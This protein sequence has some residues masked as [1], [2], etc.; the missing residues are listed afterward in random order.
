MT[1]DPL[2]ST[3]AAPG[4]WWRY[5]RAFIAPLL[6]WFIVLGAMWPLLSDWVNGQAVFNRDAIQEWLVE[7]RNPTHTLSDLVEGYIKRSREYQDLHNRLLA[8]GQQPGAPSAGF[9]GEVEE[10]LSPAQ[11]EIRDLRYRHGWLRL[12]VLP[13]KRFEIAEFLKSLGEPPTKMYPGQLP[14]F[15]VIYRMAVWFDE[16]DMPHGEGVSQI[17]GRNLHDPITWDSGL[18]PGSEQY[19]EQTVRLRG[20]ATVRIVYQVR[21]W[22]Q[23]Q[24]ADRDRAK[25]VRL[26]SLLALAATAFALGWLLLLHAGERHRQHALEQVEHA[27]QKS[28]AEEERRMAAE[29]EALEKTRLAQAEEKRRVETE[30]QLLEQ[31]LAAREA[32]R[33][34]LE[35]K[36][37]LW[38]SIGIMAGAYAHNIKNLLVRP[39]DL[40]RRCLE[41]KGTAADQERMIKEVQQTLG[42]VTERLQQIL[43]TVRR[44]PNQ[45]EVRPLDLNQMVRHLGR[46]WGELSADRWQADLVLEPTP[47]PLWILGDESHLQQAIENLLFNARDAMFEMRNQLRDA[48]RK[49]P[50]PGSPEWRQAMIEAAQW[51]GRVVVRC[52]RLGDQAVLEVADNGSG[53][54]EEVRQR[55]TET[56]FS[57]KRDN[58]LHQGNMVGMG[59][60]LSFVAEILKHH[61]ARLEIE[62]APG[63]GATF[64][65]VLPVREQV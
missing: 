62:S 17:D 49:G 29:R 25:R 33:Q 63:K 59:L 35:L 43:Q 40:L 1:N 46:G 23:R 28:L 12:E 64:R 51:R 37:H 22:S 52:R 24:Q 53:M 44:D 2:N 31:S 39:G 50:K 56:H 26:L 15:P 34:A 47:E 65:I 5:G 60:G 41:G 45:S 14:L 38:A 8:L 30:R 7:A 36:S 13:G 6:I 21:A 27:R 16:A 9:N 10:P 20:G 55:C 3:R 58:A 4:G 42:M 18:S 61:G 32:E 11:R 48:A 57:T 19:Q 54:T